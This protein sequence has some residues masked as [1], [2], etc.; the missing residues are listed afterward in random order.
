MSSA[1]IRQKAIGA[2][3]EVGNAFLRVEWNTAWDQQGAQTLT[4]T[5]SK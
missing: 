1:H 4:R 3:P 2:K 5:I